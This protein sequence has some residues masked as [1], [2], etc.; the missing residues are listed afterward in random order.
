M[1]L[2]FS[3]IAVTWLGWKVTRIVNPAMAAYHVDMY[4]CCCQP[5]INWSWLHHYICEMIHVALKNNWKVPLLFSCNLMW[6]H[7]KSWAY[8]LVG[9]RWTVCWW[10]P[11]SWQIN[12]WRQ[13]QNGRHFADSIFKCILTNENVRISMKISL[14]FVAKVPINNIQHWVR[15]WL[16]ANQATNHYLYQWWLDYR[17]I[18]VSTG[19]NEL[20]HGGRDK[21]ADILLMTFPNAFSSMKKFEFRWKFDW[22]V[23]P[24]GLINPV[25]TETALV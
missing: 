23:F 15:W 25:V 10:E 7:R 5:F 13:R 17:R 18:Y 19:L 4:Y 14:K 9:S 12:T 16:G 22:S 3:W 24:K 6:Q 2:I 1:S 8:I 11:T 20:T 21:M